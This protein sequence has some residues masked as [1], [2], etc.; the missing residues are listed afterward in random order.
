MEMPQPSPGHTG[1]IGRISNKDE[2]ELYLDREKEVPLDRL[3]LGALRAVVG[4]R[5]ADRAFKD[6]HRGAL[7][8]KST[9]RRYRI[10]VVR[11]RPS[12]FDGL[13]GDCFARARRS[14]R[15]LQD[16]EGGS[17]DRQRAA[18]LLRITIPTLHN[19][20]RQGRLF[21]WL[22]A[23]DRYRFPCW[24][25][26]DEFRI[27]PG[28]EQCIGVLCPRD[29]FPMR[30]ESILRFFLE[31]LGHDQGNPAPISVLREGRIVDAL[32][33]AEK[34]AQEYRTTQIDDDG[35]TGFL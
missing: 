15:Q 31:G 4:K 11:Y 16:A 29:D 5:V 10:I 34:F 1:S 17:Y 14:I 27:L 25:F 32:K 21:G 9:R 19:W 7:S 2:L 20:R 24:Q 26:Q 13:Q 18:Q 28:I 8:A 3:E 6:F 22:D 33:M 30:D 23:A 12:K 35:Q